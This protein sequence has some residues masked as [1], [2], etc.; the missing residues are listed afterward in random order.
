MIGWKELL[1]VG[2]HSKAREKALLRLEGRDYEVK[3]GE[4]LEIRFNK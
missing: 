1:D 2:S 4:C 3:D